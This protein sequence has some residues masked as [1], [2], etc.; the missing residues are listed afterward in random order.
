M[1]SRFLAHVDVYTFTSC[2]SV[3]RSTRPSRAT[4]N[5]LEFPC[6]DAETAPV[7]LDLA[8]RKTVNTKV[9]HGPARR[10]WSL[11]YHERQL[12]EEHEQVETAFQSS[13]LKR[14]KS[15]QG[16]RYR[17]VL[18]WRG[19]SV[20]SPLSG[21]C[22]IRPPSRP[23][24]SSC[25]CAPSHALTAGGHSWDHWTPPPSAL[26]REPS[27]APQL[28]RSTRRRHDETTNAPT[29]TPTLQNTIELTLCRYHRLPHRYIEASL[30]YMC[31]DRDL[32]CR[33][34]GQG[35]SGA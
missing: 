2:C 9:P 30:C 19:A 33:T 17:G 29:W 7:L 25:Q 21:G 13:L 6:S 20:G 5:V 22:P 14:I 8:Q 27:A 15:G 24:Q 18:S 28:L 31:A 26:C 4:D 23:H 10:S 34:A 11:S 12:T 1:P 32:P 35:E 3:I 16:G